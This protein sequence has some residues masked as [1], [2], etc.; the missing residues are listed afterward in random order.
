MASLFDAFDFKASRMRESKVRESKVRESRV[1]DSV[2]KHSRMRDSG[3]SVQFSAQEIPPPPPSLI[4]RNY[5]DSNFELFAKLPPESTWLRS[6]IVERQ[7]SIADAVWQPRLIV[8][9]DDAVL[10][11]KPDSDSVVDR[12]ALRSITFVG[13]VL[14]ELTVFFFDVWQSVSHSASILQMPIF[15]SLQVNIAQIMPPA[16]VKKQMQNKAR[17]G[18]SLNLFAGTQNATNGTASGADGSN[19]G[20]PAPVSAAGG[21][22]FAFEIRTEV[23]PIRISRFLKS[24][25]A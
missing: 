18:S 12:L 5:D 7:T 13:Q 22:K 17:R 16:E 15:C 14:T 20:A 2:T 21:D 8:L 10:F 1:R 9:T 6:G 11:A 24:F 19:S 4:R 25:I 23:A 3:K